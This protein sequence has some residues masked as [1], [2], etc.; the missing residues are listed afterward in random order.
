M[1]HEVFLIGTFKAMFAVEFSDN[2]SMRRGSEEQTYIFFS[3]FLDECEGM[4]YSM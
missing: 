3:D 4:L 1:L 2:E